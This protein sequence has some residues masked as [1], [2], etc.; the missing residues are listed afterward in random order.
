M[1]IGQ[2]DYNKE[3][4]RNMIGG[5]KTAWQHATTEGQNIAFV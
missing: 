2:V 5:T 4:K 3:A 1:S